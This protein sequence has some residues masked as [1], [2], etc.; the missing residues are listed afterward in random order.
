MTDQPFQTD[1]SPVDN[2]RDIE[3][4]TLKA[5]LERLHNALIPFAAAWGIGSLNIRPDALEDL[6]LAAQHDSYIE[7]LYIGSGDDL[8]RLKGKHLHAA[9]VA[10]NGGEE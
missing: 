5:E 4:E 6:S 10:V 2:R 3:L 8:T 1:D 9:F 7:P